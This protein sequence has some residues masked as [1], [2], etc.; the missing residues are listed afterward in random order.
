MNAPVTADQSETQKIENALD[1]LLTAVACYEREPAL[2][3]ETGA[4]SAGALIG[5]YLEKLTTWT[6]AQRSADELL[7]RPVS[8]ALRRAI[9]TLGKRLHEI[10]GDRLMH[11]IC[12]RVAA[13]D[14]AREGWRL[15]VID[16]RWDGIGEW[17]A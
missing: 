13:R 6:K 3:P 16:H 9:R 5:A 12:D 8:W 15:G 10:G 7:Q 17:V 2:L 11:D 1:A 14:P 4:V